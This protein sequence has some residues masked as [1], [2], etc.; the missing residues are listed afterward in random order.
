LAIRL[1]EP[2]RIGISDNVLVSLMVSTEML[3]QKLRN[4]QPQPFLAIAAMKVFVTWPCVRREDHHY[5]A[6][7]GYQLRVSAKTVG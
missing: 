3:R 2:Y 1:T 6:Y 7:I 4:K 5:T